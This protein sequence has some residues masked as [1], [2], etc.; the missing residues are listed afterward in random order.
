MRPYLQA[1]M[2]NRHSLDP[3]LQRFGVKGGLTKPGSGLGVLLV[4]TAPTSVS[5]RNP[6]YSLTLGPDSEQLSDSMEDPQGS[7]EE[8]GTRNP[9]FT[10]QAVR[11]LS[12]SLCSAPE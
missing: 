7:A 12:C 11:G 2:P 5:G 9:D 1:M 10:E 8:A 6:S 3:L 4:H